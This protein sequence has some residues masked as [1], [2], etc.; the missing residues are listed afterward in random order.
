LAPLTLEMTIGRSD[1][2]SAPRAL[3]GPPRWPPPA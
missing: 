3:T 1:A 2:P